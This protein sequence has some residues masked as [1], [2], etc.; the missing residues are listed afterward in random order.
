MRNGHPMAP[1]WVDNRSLK[2]YF[3]FPHDGAITLTGSG[4]HEYCRVRSQNR[5]DW[6]GL[7]RTASRG[8]L[9]TIRSIRHGV[10]HECTP[11]QR[12]VT[13]DMTELVRLP[14]QT[15]A[16]E[17]SRSRSDRARLAIGG[18]LHRHRP[19]T[20]RREQ[21]AQPRAIAAGLDHDRPS[22]EEGRHRRLRNPPS[23][24]ASPRTSASP[25]SKRRPASNGRPTS[26]SATR[27]SA[28]T[29]ATRNG[30]STTS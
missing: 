19:D 25:S 1:R 6:A 14:V 16:Q 4:Q 29:P 3:G 30:A 11:N 21:A 22:P 27:P 28:S 9:R 5:G 13:R 10:R 26:T 8:R 23:I 2:G 7:R 17:H 18:L 24:P 20:D 12:T 15:C